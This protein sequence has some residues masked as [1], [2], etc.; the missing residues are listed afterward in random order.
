MWRCLSIKDRHGWTGPSGMAQM[1]ARQ[2]YPAEKEGGSSG[3]PFYRHLNRATSQLGGGAGAQPVR[4][5]SQAFAAVRAAKKG[6]SQAQGAP[7]HHQDL[8]PSYEEVLR[9]QAR[10]ANERSERDYFGSQLRHGV[11]GNDLAADLE[12]GRVLSCAFVYD[13]EAGHNIALGRPPSRGTDNSDNVAVRSFGTGSSTTAYGTTSRMTSKRQG[14]QRAVP[15][16]A[17]YPRSPSSLSLAF[18]RRSLALAKAARRRLSSSSPSAASSSQ[19]R[20]QRKAAPEMP[21]LRQRRLA[22]AAVRQAER[23]RDQLRRLANELRLPSS[24][25]PGG[26][27]DTSFLSPT[28]EYGPSAAPPATGTANAPTTIYSPGQSTTGLT[29]ISRA[30][31]RFGRDSEGAYSRY[32]AW[33]DAATVEPPAAS[34]PSLEQPLPAYQPSVAGSQR[35][36]A[37]RGGEDLGLGA[38]RL[39]VAARYESEW[40]EKLRS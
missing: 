26:R 5:I 35:E 8:S 17:G 1:I 31:R 37:L 22:L 21:S 23:E 36:R 16:A 10:E 19:R 33:Y 25:K 15:T 3:P 20:Y 39:P 30:Q 40:V 24:A 6:G 29:S 12:S 4:S 14:K 2:E 7:A 28:S 38:G 9:A 34:R 13:S 27:T 32:E 18:K 11:K